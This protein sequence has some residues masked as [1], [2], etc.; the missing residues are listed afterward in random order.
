MKHPA[1][2]AHGLGDG[3]EEALHLDPAVQTG[4]L[5]VAI[6]GVGEAPGDQGVLLPAAGDSS[7]SRWYSCTHLAKPRCSI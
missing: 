6:T 3:G 4:P 1:L 2:L 5:V 7:P